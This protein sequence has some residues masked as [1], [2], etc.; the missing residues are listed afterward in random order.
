MY[1]AYGDTQADRGFWYSHPL[2]EIDGLDDEQLFW[3]PDA[4]CLCMLW[5]VGHIAHRERLHIGKLL[6]G[7]EKDLIPPQYEVFDHQWRSADEVR[8][9]IDSV[10]GVLDWVGNVR[11]ETS[12]FL[13]SLDDDDWHKI[14]PT[15]EFGLTTAHWVFLTVSHGALHIG[16]VQMLR[17]MLEDDQDRPC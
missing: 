5:H 1:S 13:A 7:I 14:P 9:S 17:A 11:Q 12:D 8:Q 3:T 6:Q 10:A 15:S 16:K 2:A 4:S